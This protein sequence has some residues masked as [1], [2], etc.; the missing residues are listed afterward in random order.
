MLRLTEMRKKRNMTQTELARAIGIAQPSVSDLENGIS[1]P[2]F[3]TLIR[4]ARVLE[5][6]LDEL[7]DLGSDSAAS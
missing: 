6:S 5:C 1:K 7:V 2:S 3:D 4:I